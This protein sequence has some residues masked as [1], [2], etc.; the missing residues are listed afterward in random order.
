MKILSAEQ[1]RA[2]DA[3]TIAN[4]P[5]SSLALMERAARRCTEWLLNKFKNDEQFTIVCGMGNNGG[6]GLAIVRQLNDQGRSVKCYILALS[7]TG[8]SDFEANK[9]AL[10][11]VQQD[12]IEIC[13]EVDLVKMEDTDVVIDAIFGTG[14]SRPLEGLASATVFKINQL[15]AVKIAIDIPSGLFANQPNIKDSSVF[16]ADYTLTFELPNLAF[17]L[18]ENAEFVGKWDVLPIGLS[19]EFIS[20]QNT[21]YQLITK[22]YLQFILKNRK[23]FSHKGTYGHAKLICG[24]YGKM[25]AAVLAS[26]ACLRSGVGLVTAVIPK[27]G[28]SI[29]QQ[30][31]PEAMAVCLGE[32]KLEGKMEI[33]DSFVGL[34]PGIGQHKLTQDTVL[35]ILKNASKAIVIDA[36]ALNILAKNPDWMVYIPDNSILTPHPKEFKR[37]VGTWK[38]DYEKLDKLQNLAK[39]L[40]CV[41]VLKGAHT[42]IATAEGNV[43]FNTTGNPGMATGGSGDVLTGIIT[44]LL[45]Q[46]Y[47]S[48]QAAQLGVYLHGLAGDLAAEQLGKEALIA[49]DIIDNIGKAFLQLHN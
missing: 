17:L 49:S 25:G 32:N 42:A 5:V 9:N 37:L 39:K 27:C 41:I 21:N 22:K 44:G 35:E 16:K 14:L 47:K 15:N 40:N 12:A 43:I 48:I 24:S 36:D 7:Q 28:Y 2:A 19:K 20:E 8:S 6:D 45:A 13:D 11:K 30:A 34:G 4:E 31:V 26:K 29:L 33:G 38:D 1:I 3:Y 46:G 18:P 23:K 10:T